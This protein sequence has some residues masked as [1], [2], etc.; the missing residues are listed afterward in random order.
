MSVYKAEDPD[1]FRRAICS[2][3]DQDVPPEVEIR[4]YLGVDGPVPKP[5]KTAI[6]DLGPT[7]YRCEYFSEARGLVHVL[8]DLIAQLGEE[9]LVFR[10]DTDDVSHPLRF[11]RQIEAM[12][13]SPELDVVGTA[14]TEIGPDGS[15]RVVRFAGSPEIARATAS[16]RV[17]IAHPTACLR[18]HVFDRFGGYPPGRSDRR[19]DIQLWFECLAAGFKLASLPEPLYDFT[20][21]PSFWKRRGLRMGIA[22]FRTFMTG[23]WLLE[24]MTWKFVYPLAR[25]AF[26][27]LPP[28]FQERCYASQ[29][30][31]K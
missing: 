5:L 2:I 21:S 14:I 27:L 12:D 15:R 19:E 10:M 30:R 20:I 18:R 17:P 24:G 9:Q 7:L 23:V 4:M 13:R 16:K 31:Q 11:R 3:R 29:W 25:F 22:E 1:A 6:E 8:N 28:W 26:R